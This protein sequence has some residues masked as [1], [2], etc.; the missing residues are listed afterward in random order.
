MTNLEDA[1]LLLSDA[2]RAECAEEL[3]RGICELY[4]VSFIRPATITEP[5]VIIK[6]KRMD[7]ALL[8]DGVSYSPTRALAETLGYTVTW[9]GSTKTTFID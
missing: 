8:I 4:A 5:V 7:G 9:N 2:Y 6:G 1:R 3:A